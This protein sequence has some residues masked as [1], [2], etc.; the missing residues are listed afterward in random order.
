MAHV[1]APGAGNSQGSP[2][3]RPGQSQWPVR[4]A[5]TQDGNNSAPA[6]ALRAL[7]P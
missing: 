7:A 6:L 5:A 1:D 3:A 2:R 4:W